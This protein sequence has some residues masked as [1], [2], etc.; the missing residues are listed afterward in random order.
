MQRVSLHSYFVI[1]LLFSTRTLLI[2][3]DTTLLTGHIT[4]PQGASVASAIVTLYDRDNATRIRVTSDLTGAYRFERVRAGEYLLEVDSPGLAQPSVLTVNLK[5]G[6]PTVLDV[7][8]GMAGHH[9]E[10]VVTASGT[11]QPVDEVSK[12]ITVVDQRNIEERDEYSISEALRPV[13]GLRVQQLGGPGA[14][15]TIKIRGLRNEDTAVLIDGLRF[16][17][18]AATQGDASGLLE[19]LIVT[20]IDR[21]E[22]LRGSGSSLYGSNAIGG[23]INLVTAD[24][25]GRLRGKLATEGGSLG[26]FRGRAQISGGIKDDRLTYSLGLT[27]LNVSKGVDGDDAARNSSGQG[28][29]NLRLSPSATLSGRIYSADSFVQLNSSPQALGNVPSSGIVEAVPLS[30]QVLSLYESGT[31]LSQLDTGAATFIPSAND[32]DGSRNARFFSGAVLFTH[33]PSERLSYTASYQGLV[34]NRSNPNGPGGI[35]FQPRGNVDSEFGGRIQTLNA[36]L[37]YQLGAFQSIHAGGEFENERFVNRSVA[38]IAAENSEVEVTQRS[39]AFF[40]QDQLRLLDGRLQLSAAFRTQA[41]A[42][43]TPRFMPAAAPPYQG[44]SFASPPTA[45]TGDGSVAYFFRKTGTKIR[46]HVGNGYRAPSLYERFGTFYGSFGYSIYG[47]PR[48]RPDR[49]VAFD[50]GIDQELLQ[51]KLR[52]S[53]SYFYTRLREVII[54]DFSGAIDPSNDPFGRFGGYR[55]TGGGLARGM[56]VNVT[57]RPVPSLDL[58][59]SYTYTNADQSRPLVE[60]IL[61]SFAIPDH[62]FSFVATQH[63]GQRFFVNFDFVSSSSFLAPL[64]DPLT[65]ASRAFQFGGIRKADL[66]ASYRLPLSDYRSLRFHFK[67]DNLFDRDYYENGF[68]T[69]GATGI[70]G[71]QFEF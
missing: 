53:T 67:V 68:R 12:A 13:P 4:D 27:H 50:V 10:V 25:G 8:L 26:L 34:S 38:V 45:H 63:I 48:L 30:K 35:G 47:D 6:Q 69:P 54:F 58:E 3:A 59:G 33:Q 16:R 14:F 62:Q 60:E 19:D 40:V 23:V 46:G 5:L 7:A 66:G 64:F 28:R 31:P 49:S 39:G 18:A 36:G 44:L 51:G 37:N 71:V 57:I 17:D 9:D 20:N 65:F 24:G 43:Q 55:N 22:V 61:R 29:L 11:P 21:L 42:L 52:A 2:G 41:F 15:T 1:V 70:A 32:P 56:E